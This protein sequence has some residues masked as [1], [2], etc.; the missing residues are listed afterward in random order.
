M[1]RFRGLWKAVLVCHE[2]QLLAMRESKFQQLKAMTISH[3]SVASTASKDLERELTKWYRSFN[4]WISSQRAYVE[5]LNGW[6]K[7]WLPEVQEELTAD[8]VPPFSPGRLGCPPVFIIS[9]DWFQA[10]ER[11]SKSGVLKAMD[12]FAKLVREFKKSQE[13]EQRQK[14]KADHA[15]R[16]YNKKREDLKGELGLSTSPD[17]AAVMENPRYSHDDRVLDLVK[18]RR[19]RDEE[20]IKHDKTLSHCHVAASA[21]LPIGLVPMLQQ[22]ISFFQDNLQVYMQIRFQG[23]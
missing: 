21:T 15:S 22:I 16:G 17:V 20:R 6:L 18:T 1:C 12:H 7:K 14:R 8:G 2:K 10:I 9:N 19:R 13:D 3:S 5:A 4:K 23:P 11:V